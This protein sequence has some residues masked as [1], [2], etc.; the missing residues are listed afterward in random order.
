MRHRLT[1]FHRLAH[2]PGRRLKTEVEKG[3]PPKT[4]TKL[5]L[6]LSKMQADWYRRI[7]LRDLQALGNGA[8]KG[9]H[10]QPTTSGSNDASS[11]GWPASC[12][13]VR[14]SSASS[15]RPAA[16]HEATS[17]RSSGSSSFNSS[18]PVAVGRHSF[19]QGHSSSVRFSWPARTFCAEP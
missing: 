10:T 3:L 15:R 18:H 6:P 1:I 7:L 2:H 9:I 19:H 16:T 8:G 11:S 12:A 14:R 4:E 17:G 13:A 5:F